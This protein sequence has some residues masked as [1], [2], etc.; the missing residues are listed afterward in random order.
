MR[1]LF[2]P[3]LVLCSVAQADPPPLI[4]VHR[5]AGI[6]QPYVDARTAVMVLGIASVSSLPEPWL[7][8][9]HDSFESIESVDRALAT[10][11]P[12][13]DPAAPFE[14][15]GILPASRTVIG[16]YRVGLSYRPE[17]AEKSLPKARY[18]MVSIHRVRPGAD[19]GFADL[20]RLR[21][22]RYDSINL[23]RPEIA[24]QV[25][26]RLPERIYS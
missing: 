10:M 5:G 16:L 4:R 17:E 12:V 22:A 9:A 20:I 3:L 21:R 15:D 7:I 1:L 13:R 25:P 2:A 19:A 11:P 24:Y 18:L 8:E 23:D 14:S 6:V 26:A